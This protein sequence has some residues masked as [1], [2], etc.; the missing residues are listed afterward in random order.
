VAFKKVG[1]HNWSLLSIEGEHSIDMALDRS[2]RQ[3]IEALNFII[4]S[5]QGLETEGPWS[6]FQPCP[7]ALDISARPCRLLHSSPCHLSFSF[8][9]P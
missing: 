2:T 9:S 3:L 5:S 8:V 1:L 4:A 7:S 6:G